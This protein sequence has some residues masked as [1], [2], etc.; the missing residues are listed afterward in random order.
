MDLSDLDLF[1]SD[2]AVEVTHVPASGA[3]SSGMALFDMPGT[4][5]I[6]GDLLATDYSLRYPAVTFQTV[7]RGD[8]FTISGADYT[9]REAPQPASFEGG[10]MMVP[11]A[12]GA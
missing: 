8:T 7:R 2:F 4:T 12:R 11:L 9:V 10:E 5:L 1:Y 3:P 6:G